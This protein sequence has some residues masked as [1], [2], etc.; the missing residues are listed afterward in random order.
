[1]LK[2]PC[3]LLCLQFL[4]M[5]SLYFLKSYVYYV[6]SIVLNRPLNWN[7]CLWHYSGEGISC[8]AVDGTTKAVGATADVLNLL[9]TSLL[10][11][12]KSSD[13]VWLCLKML[14]IPFSLYQNTVFCWHMLLCYS[15]HTIGVDF[16]ARVLFMRI[17]RDIWT[18]HKYK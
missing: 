8:T 18:L 16:S 14:I 12:T 10:S 7:A 17:M 15:H 5:E 6:S 9:R 2:T 11:N 3:P 1:M 4:E 13:W